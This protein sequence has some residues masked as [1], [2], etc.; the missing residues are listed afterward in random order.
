[1]FYKNFPNE[2]FCNVDMDNYMLF[3]KKVSS[4]KINKFWNIWSM[5]LFENS[6]QSNRTT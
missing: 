6:F 4:L 1:M 2:M 3:E 5:H